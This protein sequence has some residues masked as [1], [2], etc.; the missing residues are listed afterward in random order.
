[1]TK[2]S[3]KWTLLPVRR[4][5]FNAIEEVPPR[6]SEFDKMVRCAETLSQGF[7]HVR[8]GFFDIVGKAM[9]AEILPKGPRPS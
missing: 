3:D 7:P 9:F 6:P 8:V 1:M 4:K 5:D 2:C